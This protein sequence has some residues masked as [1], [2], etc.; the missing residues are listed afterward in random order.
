MI[1][2]I[3]EIRWT[4]GVARLG[5]RLR[6]A[7]RLCMLLSTVCHPGFGGRIVIGVLGFRFLSRVAHSE[8]QD[9]G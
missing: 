8:S 7:E 3:P 9:P 4:S 2:K 5:H 1:L 6:C